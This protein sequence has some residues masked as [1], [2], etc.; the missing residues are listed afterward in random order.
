MRAH[1]KGHTLATAAVAVDWLV[2][3]GTSQKA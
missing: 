3:Q 2:R 1:S